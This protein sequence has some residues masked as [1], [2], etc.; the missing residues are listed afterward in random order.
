MKVSL[1]IAVLFVFASE[2]SANNVV[3]FR[4]GGKRYKLELKKLEF[5][6]VK[7][8]KPKD[9]APPLSIK[10][11]IATSRKR[12]EKFLP[13]RAEQFELVSVELSSNRF[14]GDESKTTYWCYATRYTDDQTG[15]ILCFVVMF[16][17]RT[18]V[19][20]LTKP[21]LEHRIR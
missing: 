7:A 12:L 1:I 9:G 10:D 8:W 20:D 17:R 11:A 5:K 6:G 4:Y 14:L 2:S 21:V 16:D 3:Y 18:L 19:P 13:K 15:D